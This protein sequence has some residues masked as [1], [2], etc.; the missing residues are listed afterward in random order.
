[1]RRSRSG[2][3]KA[4]CKAASINNA[5]VQILAE[6][7]NLLK[8]NGNKKLIVFFPGNDSKAKSWF[9]TAYIYGRD[10]RPIRHKGKRN[11]DLRQ[12]MMKNNK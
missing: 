11:V 3:A 10:E 12:V 6:V 1:M 7:M 4:E 8:W 2:P 9:R 5:K